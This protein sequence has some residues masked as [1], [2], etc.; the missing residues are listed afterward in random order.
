M[1]SIRLLFF[2]Q[3]IHA[4]GLSAWVARR[5]SES[6]SG[7]TDMVV[8]LR[9]RRWL[10]EFPILCLHIDVGRSYGN[11]RKASAGSPMRRRR[12]RR[13][14]QARQTPYGWR[15]SRSPAIGRRSVRTLREPSSRNNVDRA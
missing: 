15:V 12:A 8:D 13:Q 4:A 14:G 3:Q 9:H 11:D 1:F 7:K 10:S 5:L 2:T 6:L